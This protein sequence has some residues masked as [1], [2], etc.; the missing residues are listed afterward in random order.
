MAG[1]VVLASTAAVLLLPG[2]H[3]GLW[4]VSMVILLAGL[5]AICLVKGEKPRWRWGKD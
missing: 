3:I 2:N 5:I 1:F 4:I